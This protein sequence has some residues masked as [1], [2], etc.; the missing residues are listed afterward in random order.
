MS[1]LT[2][3]DIIDLLDGNI[4]ELSDFESDTDS[5]GELEIDELLENFDENETFELLDYNDIEN[6]N[7][8]PEVDVPGWFTIEKKDMKW[9]QKPFTPPKTNLNEIEQSNCPY[10]IQS[11]LYVL[12]F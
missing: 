10:E 12:F 9:V 8:F 3:T 11:P 5:V 2:H 6:V 1:K 4:S 7:D